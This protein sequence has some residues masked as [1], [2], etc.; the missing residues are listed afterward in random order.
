MIVPLQVLGDGGAQEPEWWASN[1]FSNDFMTT[2][3][4]ATGL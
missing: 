1:S 2:D 4:K 3:V